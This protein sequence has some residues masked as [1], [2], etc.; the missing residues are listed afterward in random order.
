MKKL[1]IVS[2]LGLVISAQAFAAGTKI[3]GSTVKNRARVD[4][5]TNIA[6]GRGSEANMATIKLKNSEVKNSRII[7]RAR[8]KRSTNKALRGGEANMGSV[9][10]E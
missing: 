2:A 7:N 3:E 10:A 8:V 6:K 4:N 1:I 9:V 5:S